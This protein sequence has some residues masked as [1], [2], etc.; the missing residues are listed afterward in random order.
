VTK[1][2]IILAKDLNPA[3]ALECGE[4][5]VSWAKFLTSQGFSVKYI[6]LHNEGENPGRYPAKPSQDYDMWWPPNQIVEFLVFLRG[7]LDRDG[8][9]NVGMIRF[10]PPFQTH[11]YEE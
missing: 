11:K 2:K 5:L 6:S 1:E 4:Y 8:L 9:T 7:M 10:S 3:L